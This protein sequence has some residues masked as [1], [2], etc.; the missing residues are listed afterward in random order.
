MREEAEIIGHGV[1][2]RATIVAALLALALAAQPQI[3]AADHIPEEQAIAAFQALKKR[4]DALEAENAT[5]Q[6]QIDELT[7]LLLSLLPDARTVFITSQA[8]APV[9][10]FAGLDDADAL[11]QQHATAAGFAGSF[12]AWL[13]DETSSPSTR[14]TRSAGPYV[15]PD[16][17]L[18]AAG[19]D[20]LVDCTNPNCLFH[21]IDLDEFQAP[22]A[23]D[24]AWTGTTQAGE[25]DADE[26]TCVG[27]TSTDT[28]GAAGRVDSLGGWTS[29]LYGR[30]C[31]LALHLYCFQ[32]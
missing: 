11:C 19:W 22:A 7:A 12:K 21:P 23:G 16:G 31:G 25:V 9:L 20:D 6:K 30:Y 24:Y 10:D 27:W 14:F 1:V 8:Y 13:S 15:L 26:G 2:R 4:V 3:A 17:T 28:G 32:Q 29:V 18:V 5:Q